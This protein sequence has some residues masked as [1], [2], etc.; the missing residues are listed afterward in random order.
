MK[1]FKNRYF[2][3]SRIF[4]AKFRAIVSYFSVD[5]TALQD[6]ELSGVNRN[7]INK[8]YLSLHE[9]IAKAFEDQRPMFG[10]F[11]VDES[12]FGAARVKG[13]RGLGD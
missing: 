1:N 8:I 5:Y 10:V 9:R 2:V 3:F 6:A 11:E 13:K 7:T 12:L 4:E